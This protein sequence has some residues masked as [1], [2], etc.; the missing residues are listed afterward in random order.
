[1]TRIGRCRAAAL[2]LALTTAACG[3]GD[4]REGTGAASIKRTPVP[5]NE[6]TPV[7]LEATIDNLVAEINRSSI[8]PMH[9]TVLLKTL[10]TFFAPIATGAHRAMGEIGVTGNVVGAFEQTGDQQKA[11]ELQNQQIEQAVADGAEGIGISPFGDAT[12]A[13]IDE[14]VAKGVH[15]VT[16]DTDL[17]GSERAIYVGTLNHAGERFNLG[18]DVVPADKVD[19]YNDFL[20]SIGATQ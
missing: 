16:L 7:E 2:G 17:D 1:M 15:V 8:E 9:M 11:M 19:A 4:A 13:V 14:A 10:T 6:F 5:A 12:V 20:A 18:L 3:A